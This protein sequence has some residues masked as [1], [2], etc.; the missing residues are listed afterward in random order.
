MAEQLK[1][2][3]SCRQAWVA[4]RSAFSMVNW[5]LGQKPCW[6]DGGDM[7]AIKAYK[8]IVSYERNRRCCLIVSQ[9]DCRSVIL[10]WDLYRLAYQDAIT[11]MNRLNKCT[12]YTQFIIDYDKEREFIQ[13][14]VTILTY[15]R[16]RRLSDIDNRKLYQYT[17][18][19]N[20]VRVWRRI[21]KAAK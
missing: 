9:R 1:K 6:T 21:E 19:F 13:A 16:T 7:E 14:F 18:Q 20:L 3:K 4:Y 8:T 15:S 12:D 17:R 2:I 11:L 5:L 10:D